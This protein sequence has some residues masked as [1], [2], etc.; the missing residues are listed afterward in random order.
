MKL[1][2]PLLSTAAAC[3]LLTGTALAN[4][5]I[6]FNVPNGDSPQAQAYHGKTYAF[7][8][9]GDHN[10]ALM[11]LGWLSEDTQGNI[12]TFHVQSQALDDFAA[13]NSTFSYKVCVTDG[14]PGSAK[15]LTNIEEDVQN[16]CYYSPAGM[17]TLNLDSATISFD[18]SQWNYAN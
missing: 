14:I 13:D 4:T 8:A 6:T 2:K 16:G 10:E 12:E 9:S 5:N 7:Y 3:A 1:I 18:A 17:D 11:S 15:L